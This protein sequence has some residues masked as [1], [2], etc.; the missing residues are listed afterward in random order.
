MTKYFTLQRAV[1]L[2]NSISSFDG[3]SFYFTIDFITY[4]LQITQGTSKHEYE[5]IYKKSIHVKYMK[6][7]TII[8]WVNE[9]LPNFIMI[10]NISILLKDFSFTMII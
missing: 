10:S 1:S 9:N 6:M 4:K 3:L 5:Y 7:S 2:L 8:G